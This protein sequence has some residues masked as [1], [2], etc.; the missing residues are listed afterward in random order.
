MIICK[1]NSPFFPWNL[2]SL[3]DD[4]YLVTL[5]DSTHQITAPSS[6]PVQG[7]WKWSIYSQFFLQEMEK[8]LSWVSIHR[9]CCFLKSQNYPLFRLS[10]L[11]DRDCFLPHSQ[12]LE[13]IFCQ[14]KVT[15]SYKSYRI[16]E[17]ITQFIDDWAT[18]S[19]LV[20]L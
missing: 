15:A 7:F 9:V 17:R 13:P 3:L 12:L 11:Q 4:V 14:I 6:F 5:L 16:S 20:F 8:T 19:E 2:S 1:L 10:Y 18:S